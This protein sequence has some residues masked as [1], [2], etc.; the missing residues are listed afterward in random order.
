MTGSWAR[1]AAQEACTSAK[2]EAYVLGERRCVEAREV[3][4]RPPAPDRAHGRG[5]EQRRRPP[6]EHGDSFSPHLPQINSSS[7]LPLQAP[8]H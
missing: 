1:E 5:E 2:A 4:A 7:L 3:T 6:P 8:M